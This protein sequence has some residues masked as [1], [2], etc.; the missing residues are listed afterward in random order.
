MRKVT[1]ANILVATGSVPHRPPDIPWDDPNV[2]DSDTILELEEMPRRMVVIGAGVIGCEYASMFAA[3]GVNVTLIDKRNELLP[4]LD[5]EMSEALRVAFVTMGIDVRLEDAH[6]EFKKEG[7]HSV[8]NLQKG[9]KIVCDKVL[10]CGGRSGATK[11]L[12]LES[13]GVKLG[14]R[15]SVAVDPHYRSNVPNVF[16]A[17]DVIGFPALASTSMEQGRLAALHAFGMSDEGSLAHGAGTT[18]PYGIYTIPEVSCVGLSEE[19]AKAKGISVVSG[20]GDF[21]HNARAKINGFSHGF[22]K[23]VFEKRTRICIGAHAI[24]DRA[25]ELIHIGQCAVAFGGTVDAMAGMVF[26]YPTLSE[27][28]KHAARDALSRWPE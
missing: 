9:G 3:L 16:A 24:G 22:V 13:A 10:F 15:G 20:K 7:S 25:T 11:G 19:D 26:N 23:L 27:C 18:L 2:E 21:E 5:M 1:A 4:F 12:D 6:A 8:V 28:F 17:G 14:V